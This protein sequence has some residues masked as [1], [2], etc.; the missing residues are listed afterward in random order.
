MSK[1][2]LNSQDFDIEIKKLLDNIENMNS[3]I[4]LYKV[5]IDEQLTIAV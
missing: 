2:L 4:D 5:I 1:E 3:N